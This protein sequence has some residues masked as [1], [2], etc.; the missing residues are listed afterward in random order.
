M[1][2]LEEVSST[3]EAAGIRHALV[4]AL[5]L[6]AY[7]INRATVDLDLFATDASCLRPEIW[8]GLRD[9]GVAVEIRVGDWTD[10]LA[11]V[12]RFQA[13]GENPLDC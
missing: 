13:P 11:G 9:R 7:G 12:V 1:S 5:A 4:G 10:P 2:L 6:S 8:A 3:L